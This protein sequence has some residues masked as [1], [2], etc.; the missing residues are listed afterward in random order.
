MLKVL[1]DGER[2]D[3][4]PPEDVRELEEFLKHCHRDLKSARKS[5][6]VKLPEFTKP[7]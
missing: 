4:V 2:N 7:R 3:K 6:Q 5:L 1:D